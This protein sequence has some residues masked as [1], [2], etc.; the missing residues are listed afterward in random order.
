MVS[1]WPMSMSP[2]LR[3]A[4]HPRRFGAHDAAA[5]VGTDLG[6]V[7]DVQVHARGGRRGWAH[8]RRQLSQRRQRRLQTQ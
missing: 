7:V 3:V 5:E 1:L 4:R 2:R 8:R 6:L